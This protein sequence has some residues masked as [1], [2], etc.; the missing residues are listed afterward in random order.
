MNRN[1]VCRNTVVKVVMYKHGKKCEV[2]LQVNT[3]DKVSSI[4]RDVVKEFMG[5]DIEEIMFICGEKQIYPSDIIND[6]SVIELHILSLG[7]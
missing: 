4:Y 1:D 6:C 2:D 3:C 7:G 5:V